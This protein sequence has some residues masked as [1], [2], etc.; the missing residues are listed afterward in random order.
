MTISR[1]K[2]AALRALHRAYVEAE[3]DEA[4]SDDELAKRRERLD[5][6][7][8]QVL[9]ALLDAADAAAWATEHVSH[10]DVEVSGAGVTASAE[11]PR[12]AAGGAAG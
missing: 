10:G 2:R 1:E 6:A 9:P 12:P 4:T 8:R 11:V 3:A 7:V 5:A